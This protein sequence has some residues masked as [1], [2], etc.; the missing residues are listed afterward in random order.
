MS[1]V[2]LYVTMATVDKE[3]AIFDFKV[4]PNV[5]PYCLSQILH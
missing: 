5:S 2:F 3:T 1:D 4:D